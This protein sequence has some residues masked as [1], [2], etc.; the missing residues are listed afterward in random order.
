[1]DGERGRCD[2]GRV[3]PNGRTIEALPSPREVPGDAARTGAARA[4]G[5]P[6]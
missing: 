4:R 3:S 6:R 2:A 5:A 1:M